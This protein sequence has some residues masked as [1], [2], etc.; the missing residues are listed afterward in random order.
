MGAGTKS[1]RGRKRKPA[2]VSSL[3]TPSASLTSHMSTPAA[4]GRL[5]TT[6]VP[7]FASAGMADDESADIAVGDNNKACTIPTK[8]FLQS[9]NNNAVLGT[10]LSVSSIVNLRLFP[11]IKFVCDPTAELMYS[12][13]AKSVCG[14]VLLQCSPPIDI[15]EEDWWEQARKWILRQVAVLRSSKNTQMKWS[16]MCKSK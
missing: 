3:S 7:S 16:F 15:K 9:D 10:A 12:K 13:N 4:Q 14:V 8:L 2:D 1:K 5:T 6:E 11:H